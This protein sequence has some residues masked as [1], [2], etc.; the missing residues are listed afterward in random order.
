MTNKKDVWAYLAQGIIAMLCFAS[1]PVAIRLVSADPFTIGLV[2][3]MLAVTIGFTLLTKF[4][5]LKRL[6]KKDWLWL[7]VLGFSFG[8]HWATY[9]LSIKIANASTAVVG[10]STY[11]IQIILISIVFHG[12]PFYRTDALALAAVVVGNL[13]IIPEFSFENELTRGFCL[14]IFSAFF[15]AILPSIHQKNSHMDSGTRAFG[16]FLFAGVFF[17]LF[18]P[19]MNFDLPASDWFGLLYLGLVATL[20]GHT[21]WIRVTTKV[22]AV[23]AS[24]LYYLSVPTAILLSFLILDEPMTWHLFAGTGLILAGNCLGI[25]HQLK[26][27]SFFIDSG[28]N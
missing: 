24:L 5:L 20:V 2:R 25:F 9:F 28:K 12:R 17:A 26:S 3:L 6:S 27:N 14:A 4:S 7:I 18:L 15:Y 8:I 11:G 16:Q 1:I 21:L 13:L 19:R 23:P 22:S 10:I